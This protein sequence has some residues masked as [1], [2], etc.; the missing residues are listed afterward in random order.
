[1]FSGIWLPL[2]TPFQ[3]GK[4]DVDALQKLTERYA[5]TG[6]SGFVVLGTTGEAALLSEIERVTVLQAVTEVVTNRLPVLVGVGGLATRDFVREVHRYD[7][8]DVSGYLVSAPAY[9]C[10]DQAGLLWHFEQV[11]RATQRHVVLYDVPHRTGV[12]IEADTVR[13]LSELVNVTGIKACAPERFDAFG[14]LSIDM[15]CGTDHAYPECT[16]AGGVGGILASAHVCAD[17]LLSVQ[18]LSQT[19]QHAA[20]RSLFDQLRPIIDLLFSTPNPS[21]IK[22]M[23]ALDGSIRDE[24]RMPITPVSPK[25]VTRLE[26]ARIELESIRMHATANAEHLA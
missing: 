16:A 12:G 8:W 1:M 22:A 19:G 15:L 23:L 26:R 5:Q 4:I 9:L 20:A 24:T 7:H 3:S 10:P 11:A 6:I 18:A 2:V 13:R 21:S 14:K 17:L 25:Q